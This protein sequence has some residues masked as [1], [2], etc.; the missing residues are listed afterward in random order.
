LLE[1]VH[2]HVLVRRPPDPNG[3]NYQGG[4]TGTL[5]THGQ[6]ISRDEAKRTPGA[7]IL[8]GTYPHHHVEMSLGDGSTTT[9]GHGSAPVDRGTF[10]LL[11]GPK[12][13]RRYA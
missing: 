9:V 3:N 11:P 8:F 12:T 4:Y 13:Y 1:L 7:A 6:K 2:G 5:G 10:D